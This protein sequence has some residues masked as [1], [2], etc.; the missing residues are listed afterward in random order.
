[1]LKRFEPPTFR[2]VEGY[3]YSGD[4]LDRIVFASPGTLPDSEELIVVTVSKTYGFSSVNEMLRAGPDEALARFSRPLEKDLYARFQRRSYDW[5]AWLVV[6]A[7]P[8]LA[9]G[10]VPPGFVLGVWLVVG[11]SEREDRP[12]L[13]YAEETRTVAALRANLVGRLVQHGPRVTG[14]RRPD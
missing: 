7:G 10:M 3:T 11:A 8:S 9:R 5:P 2:G 12:Q 1:M 6:V 4:L 13:L 14:L